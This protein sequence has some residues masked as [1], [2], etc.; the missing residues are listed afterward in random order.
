M[1]KLLLITSLVFVSPLTHAKTPTATEALLNLLPAGKYRTFKNYEV[2]VY[3]CAVE[4]KVNPETKAV[5]LT[6]EYLDAN[7]RHPSTS[8]DFEIT[9]QFTVVDSSSDEDQNYLTLV[10]PAKPNATLELT[11]AK[12]PDRLQINEISYIVTSSR[13]MYDEKRAICGFLGIDLTN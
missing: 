6:I 3:P 8:A 9:D 4:V 1:K 11:M 7:R 10:D 5:R 2:I 13:P 12:R